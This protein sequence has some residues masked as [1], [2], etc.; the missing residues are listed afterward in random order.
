MT[1]EYRRAQELLKSVREV[2]EI[3]VRVAERDVAASA[4]AVRRAQVDLDTSHVRSPAAGRILKILT[5]E[6]ERVGNQGLL[7][8]GDVLHMQAIAEIFETDVAL[9][10]PGLKAVVKVDCLKEP[11]TGEVA[12]IGHR[13][14]RKVVLTND[15]VS[16]TDA[17]VVEV[18]I[19]LAPEQIERV[20]RL[21]NARVEVSIEL[22]VE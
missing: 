14:A 8:L 1:L 12:E 17:R 20:A 21:S 19:R 16:D 3:D 5:H 9:L 11:L 22:P 4:A 6:G 2:R 18:R 7:E 13:V 15:P 10:R